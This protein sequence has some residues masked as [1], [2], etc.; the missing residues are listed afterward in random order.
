MNVSRVCHQ[1]FKEISHMIEKYGIYRPC[2]LSLQQLVDFA[3]TGDQK[4]SF[5][6]MKK[7]LLVRL[8]NTMKEIELLPEPLLNTLSLKIVNGWFIQSFCDL[9]K[10]DKMDTT[11]E[12]FLIISKNLIFGKGLMELKNSCGSN[13]LNSKNM[14]YF[15][16]R[17][18]LMRI[19][20]RML[21]NQHIMRFAKLS[22]FAKHE[23]DR[24]KT[25][26]DV[27]P[28]IEDA[29]EDARFLCEQ[30]YLT[31]P[32]LKIHQINIRRLAISPGESISMAY[33]PSHLYHIMFELFKNAMRAVIEFHGSHNSEH[34][35][36]PIQV[37]IVKSHEDLS[38]KASRFFVP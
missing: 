9:L 3:R 31:S 2:S 13:F 25:N 16:N 1:V 35:L 30:S 20:N 6:F 29:F 18:Y 26:L 15:L 19:S 28:L 38:L 32:N 37:L 22:T 8:A 34:D 36:P 10:F 4:E 7:E 27:V 21:M 12:N 24:I 11:E 5:L 14:Q 23:V 17:F 33:V